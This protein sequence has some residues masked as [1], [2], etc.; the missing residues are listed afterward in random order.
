M[1]MQ[2]VWFVL[3]QPEKLK[4]LLDAWEKT[5]VS[6]VTILASTGL[7]HLRKNGLL[8]EDLPLI[9][10]LDQ[11][12]CDEETSS[13]TLFTVIEEETLLEKLLTVTQQVV[14]DLNQPNS[15]ILI[16]LP[17]SHVYGLKKNS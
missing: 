17:V 10:S 4:T 6:G 5:G 13:R 7:G 14:G 3:S 8:R 11:L 9:P 12:F 16:T 2:L 1:I 15:G